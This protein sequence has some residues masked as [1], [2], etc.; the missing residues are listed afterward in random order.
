[1][2]GIY[3]LVGILFFAFNAWAEE[4]KPDTLTRRAVILDEVVVQSFKQGGNLNV[5][6]VAASTISRINLQ[7]QN[8]W[9]IKEISSFIPNLY[10]PDYG[11]KISSPVYIRG[12]GSKINAPSVGL[13]VDGIPYFEKS[14]F[15]FDLNE[16]DY[17]EVLRGPQGTL[18]GRNTMGGIINVYTKSPLQYQGTYISA[19]GGNYTNLNATLGY[20][21]KINDQFGYAVSGNY[22][23]TDGYF[24]NHYTGKNADGMNSG[25]GRVRLEWRVLPNLSLRLTQSVDYSNQGGYPY[26]PIDSTGKVSNVNYNEYSSYIRTL[27]STG[28]SLTYKADQYL[29]NSQT[30]FQYLSDQQ[31][32][33]QDFT[34][35]SVYFVTQKQKQYTFSEEINIKST[36]NHGYL[37]LFGAFAFNE[38]I[39]NNVAMAYE[40]LNYS[41]QKLYDLPTRGISFYHQSILNNILTDG[42]SLT[43]GIRYD[44][45][46]ASNDYTAY[47]DSLDLR[48][49]LGGDFSS[50]MDFSQLTPKIALQYTLP[51]SQMFYASITRGYK[52]GGFNTSFERDEDR[53][54]KPEYSWN[55]EIGAKGRFW[56][57]RIRAELCFFYI[58]WKNQQIYQMLPSGKG[59]M[60]KNAGHSRSK[61]IE[62]SLQGNLW[63]G[64]ALQ[65]NWGLT[66]AIFLN[67][68]QSATI[69]YSGNYI[70]SVPAQT[71]GL[72][73]NYR[74]PLRSKLADNLSVNLQYTGTGKLY[75]AEDNKISQPYYGILNGKISAAKG[76]ATVSLWSKNITNVEYMAYSFAMSNQ[77]YTQK[78]RPLTVGISINLRI[79]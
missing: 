66:D 45:E 39:D 7:N 52:T 38:Q 8:V 59:Q 19:S 34:T 55:Y 5:L 48:Q 13:Y 77:Q 4:E 43:L 56:E 40:R 10:A 74:I 35:Q 53:S 3:V 62:L 57:N 18:Y 21:G 75:W 15:D 25:S 70:P 1:M 33:D 9:D 76:I 28:L 31:A 32:I 69:D 2:K 20:Y 49:P 44:Y 64:F 79:Q 23:H 41:T 67:Y 46:K 61:G 16:I 37:W 11:A 42:L 22:N 63:K 14:A 73:A 6:P 12:I 17:I 71:L 68:V 29:L 58:D 60:L 78:G 65:A 30:S 27:S 26:A 72:A 50:T 51:S 47:K 36:T 24:L 54:F